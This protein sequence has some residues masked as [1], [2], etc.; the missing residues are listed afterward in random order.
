VAYSGCCVLIS[1][2]ITIFT[3]LQAE[4]PTKYLIIPMFVI[5]VIIGILIFHYEKKLRTK[6]CKFYISDESIEIFIPPGP[7]FKLSWA[8]IK[9]VSVTRITKHLMYFRSYV[10]V[11]LPEIS[12]SIKDQLDRTIQLRKFH[13]SKKKEILMLLKNYSDKL[14]KSFYGSP[15]MKG[16]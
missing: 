3:L 9:G 5:V 10:L 15:I 6:L 2:L 1:L 16:I 12:F 4:S 8:D 11:S 7:W 13:S 14:N